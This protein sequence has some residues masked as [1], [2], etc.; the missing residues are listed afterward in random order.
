MEPTVDPVQQFFAMFAQANTAVWPMQIVWY[1]VALAAI[2]LTI[3]P[4]GNSSRL[5]AAF[6]AAYYV[7]LGIVFFAIFYNSITPALADGAMFVFG[8]VLFL[9][10]GVVRHDLKFEVRWDLL[11]VVGGALVLYAFAYPVIDA[12]TGHYFPAAPLFGLAP[13]PSAIF[14]AGL[15]LWTR[16]RM[17]IYVLI[18]PLVWLLAQTPSEALAMGVIADVARVPVGVI[19]TALLIWRDYAA[20]RERLVAGAVLL[21]ALVLGLGHDDTLMELGGVVLLAMFLGPFLRQI[22]GPIAAMRTHGH[23]Q[24]PAK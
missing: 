23:V 8:G 10:A 3:R 19:A 18:V 16:P 12:V 4:F 2:G 17:P 7:W 13:C 21:I 1:A 14:T 22:R 6:L 5:I 24:A 15:L 9:I 11:G 20:A